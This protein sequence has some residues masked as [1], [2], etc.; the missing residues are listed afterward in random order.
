MEKA[1]DNKVKKYFL[2]LYQGLRPKIFYWEFINSLRKIL[3]LGSLLL[4]DSYKILCSVTVL[5]TI[6]KIQNQLRPYKS[7][8]NNEIEILGVNVG[9]ITLL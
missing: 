9:I 4:D 7:N 2:I 8:G 1:E 3:I 6:W 5:V